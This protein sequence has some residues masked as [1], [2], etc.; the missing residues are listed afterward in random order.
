[1]T[2]A[3]PNPMRR[4]LGAFVPMVMLALVMALVAQQHGLILRA[5][6]SD[7]GPWPVSESPVTPFAIGV[8]TSALA[9]D[10]YRPW[11]AKDLRTVNMFEHSAQAHASIIMWY[12]DWRTPF[13]AKQLREVSARGSTPEITWEPWNAD[14]AHAA[15]QPSYALSQI[16]AG[17]FDSYIRA[18]A[19]GLAAYGKP[20]RLRF[21]Q[22]MNG[23]WYP[24]DE[25]ANGNQKGQFIAMWRHVHHIF[26]LAGASN[27]A[28]VWAPVN[29][30]AQHYFPG[31]QWVNS[32]GVTCLNGGTAALTGRWKSFAATCGTAIAQLHS[33]APQLPVEIS[34]AG[35][36]EVGGNKAQWINGLFAFLK[37]HPEVRDVIWFNLHKEA[38]WRIQSSSTTQRS[39]TYDL[40]SM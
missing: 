11:T 33:V 20:V 3:P 22:E 40:H 12:A 35:S 32:L 14:D 9:Q 21:A 15:S 17:H 13:S 27:V 16:I 31:A 24:W 37:V 38:D 4:I 1:M 7:P 25:R 19:Q 23:S 30:N 34:E 36:A 29:G 8:T 6:S 18:W 5:A 28:W 10:A 26:D 39:F 2:A